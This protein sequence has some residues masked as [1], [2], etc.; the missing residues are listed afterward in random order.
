CRLLLY[1]VAA[2]A[3]SAGVTGLSLWSAFALAA[4]IIGLSYLARQESARGPLY[5]WPCYLLVAP[6]GLSLLVTARD[7]QKR[8]FVLLLLLGLWMAYC[9][10]SA[11]WTPRRNVGRTV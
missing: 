5:S 10:R 2:S 9:L 6:I 4:Y 3:A 8:A 1:L 7:Y 11:F